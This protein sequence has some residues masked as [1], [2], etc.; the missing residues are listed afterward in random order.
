MPVMALP[1][2]V[3]WYDL[4]AAN[5]TE[6][7]EVLQTDA[8]LAWAADLLPEGRPAVLD[9]GAGSG[10]DS[11]WFAGCGAD[12]VTVEPSAAMREEGQKRHSDQRLR[13]VD[14]ALPSLLH[15]SRL[16]ISFDLILISAV[17]QHVSP[18]DRPRAVRKLVALLK[19]GGLLLVT[20]RL[21]EP[22]A[23]RGMH[24]VGVE[25][26]TRLA[27][28]H[29][30]AVVRS[31]E[32]ADLLN[33]SDVRW[34][35]MALRLPDDG[36]GALPLLRHVILNDAKSSTYK[37]A[38]L[39]SL[40]RIADGAAGLARPAD[41]EHVALPMGLVALTWLR[42]YLPL[43]RANLPQAPANRQEGAALGFVKEGVRFLLKS[44]L[45]PLDLRIGSRFSDDT[46]RAVRAALS[47][48]ASTIA[49]MPA[50][51]MTFP[52]GGPVLQVSRGAGPPR[53]A[54]ELVL[55]EA[56][57]LTFGVM[58]VPR[59]LW[60][61]CQ[62]FSCWVEPALVAEWARLM[63]AYAGRQDRHLNEGALR[64]A[65][66]WSEPL[67]DVALPRSLALKQLETGRGLHCVWSGRR[68]G[69]ES[70][71]I[72]HCVP[73]AAWPCSDL[74]NLMPAHRSINQHQKRDRLP[75]DG[76]LATAAER[77]LDWWKRAYLQG[78]ILLPE[79][80]VVE[81]R[82]SLPGL[83]DASGSGLIGEDV[84]AA[85]RLQQLRLR[86]DQQVP[87]WAG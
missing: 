61:A 20:L 40:C 56:T 3:R 53:T 45:P 60:Q 28:E 35:G 31:H 78:G 38:L 51:H 7:H 24:P 50:T 26:L 68:L 46:G 15:T 70:L 10:R 23:G 49:T 44:G 48:A 39:R 74:W 8:L 11:A 58:R 67:R 22:E 17:W 62:R 27:R 82:A 32:M 73:W 81:A 86:H 52:N 69:A 84:F 5:A 12:V 9:V 30:L 21:G 72:D 80:F 4:H 64:K 34:V 33:R 76:L 63:E 25:E 41:D 66:T 42:L 16:G 54:S 87:E 19:P 83:Q 79:R 65:M 75:S 2:S 6:Q 59:H 43:L 1:D 57:L 29:G 85:L 14:D 13:W 37:L 55:D 18:G 71:D 47:E 36:T 77:I